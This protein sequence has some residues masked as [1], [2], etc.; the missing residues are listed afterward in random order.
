MASGMISLTYP[1]GEKSIGGFAIDAYIAEAYHYENSVT[2]LTVEDG[3]NISDHV[4][5]KPDRLNIEAFIGA[6][7]F[8][9]FTGERI[10]ELSDI[11]MPEDP[12]TRIRQAHLELLRM[13]RSRQPLTVVTGL[14][15]LTDMV[16]TSYNYHRDVD[17]GADLPFTMS[18]QKV[19]TV[20]SEETEIAA[21]SAADGGIANI[22][23]A[24]TSNVD[25]VCS[26]RER[27]RQWVR[28]GKAT[29]SE[30]YAQWGAP[31]PG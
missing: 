17:T 8:E 27:W 26:F 23:N 18:F 5:E 12:K 24:G 7:K 28:S 16:I 15:T 14:D 13:K 22:G 2:N 31:F 4:I 25:D 29:P 6:T 19:K 21:L 3:S 1:L 30:Y 20:Q 11:E 10:R 9:T